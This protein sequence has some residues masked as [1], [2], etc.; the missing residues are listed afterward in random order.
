[1]GGQRAGDMGAERAGAAGD[2]DGVVVAPVA[3]PVVLA[4]RGHGRRVVGGRGH[5][6]RVLGGR[7]RLGERHT[8]QAAGVR[9]GSP[10]GDLVLLATEESGEPGEAP[11]VGLR[12]DVGE[13]APG[14]GQFQ[15]DGTPESPG[16]CLDR[17]G[18]RV[19][20]VD[21]DGTAG[22]GPQPGSGPG[23]GVHQ[24]LGGG[25]AARHGG[26]V[27]VG[28]FVEGEQREHSRGGVAVGVRAL[29][30]ARGEE[31]GEGGGVLVAGEV[32]AFDAQAAGGEGREYVRHP[33]VVGVPGGDEHRPA[34]AGH[35]AAGAG[36]RGPGDA[37]APAVQGRAQGTAAAP[38]RQRGQ[39]GTEGLDVVPGDLQDGGETGDV[40]AL[41]G[42]PEL[43]VRGVSTGRGGGRLGGCQP[44]PLAT[45]GVG[46]EVDAL[47]PGAFVVRVPVDVGAQRP[48]LPQ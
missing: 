29:A 22:Q 23:Q 34:A 47:G 26:V 41:D 11:G 45:E 37:V 38:G 5:A 10:Y 4:G 43:A 8:G 18:Q 36:Q 42:R 6:R 16:L 35:G 28:V 46:G 48:R 44:V 2:Q 1:M 9:A 17:R 21:R 12:G 20:A 39:Q 24:V 33:G 25:E 27:G 30:R 13:T 31:G 19:P 3:D 40:A 14:I 15:G 7:G 32:V